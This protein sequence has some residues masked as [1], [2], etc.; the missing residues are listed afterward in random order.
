MAITRQ[1]VRVGDCDQFG[2]VN[3]AVYVGLVQQALAEVVSTAGLGAD[4]QPDGDYWWQLRSLTAD[5]RKPAH[6]GHALAAHVWLVD[7][8]STTCSVGCDIRR[9]DAG[10]GN[11]EQLLFRSLSTWARCTRGSGI[12]ASLPDQVMAALQG[13]AATPP[14]AVVLPEDPPEVRHFHWDHTVMRCEVGPSD[15]AHPQALFQW[16]EESIFAATA[17]AGWSVERCMAL[18]FVVLQIRHETE[19]YAMARRGETVQ[20]NSRLVDVHRL[21]GTWL[22]EVRRQPGGDLLARNFSTGVYL[23]LAGRPAS[24]PP[25]MME[26][27]QFGR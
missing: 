2:H 26:A 6:W 15:Q 14:R 25:G 13:D 8:T 10:S 24:P 18:D 17:Q 5:Y 12:A 9:E 4:L 22:Q 11:Q 21:R 20:L 27:I 3:N 7:S 19:A 16:F 1:Q 23:N